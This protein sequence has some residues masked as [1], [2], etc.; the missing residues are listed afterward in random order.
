MTYHIFC[1]GFPNISVSVSD[2]LGQK[3]G[4]CERVTE[5]AVGGGGCHKAG[6]HGV[7]AALTR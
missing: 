7:G 2:C 6:G 3:E 5:A 4:P 1:H